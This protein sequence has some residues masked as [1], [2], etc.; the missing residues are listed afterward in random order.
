MVDVTGARTVLVAD[1]EPLIAHDIARILRGGGFEVVGVVTDASR[2]TEAV[3]THAPALALVDIRFGLQDGIDLVATLPPAH[4]PR[5][6]Y[7]SAFTDAE[8]VARAAL[9]A[10]VGFVAKPFSEEQ[11]LA[12][13]R[14]ALGS[15]F[16]PRLRGAPEPIEAER[17]RLAL[18]KIAAL[19]D[20][21]RV[22]TPAMP[23]ERTSIPLAPSL[24]LSPREH[25]VVMALVR[26]GRVARVAQALGIS[27]HTVRNH[28]KAVYQKLGVHSLDELFDRV[29]AAQPSSE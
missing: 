7:V 9:T 13:V 28:L 10:C 27:A 1:D 20:E 23:I 15:S 2:F 5:V 18:E 26:H 21:V 25:E 8:T 17:A 11:L 6:V 14:V 19:L 24:D 16:E 22:P 3:I 12:A 29:H 4:R